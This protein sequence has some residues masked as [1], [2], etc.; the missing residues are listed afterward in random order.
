MSTLIQSHKRHK[1]WLKAIKLIQNVNDL[2]VDIR[3][4]RGTSCAQLEGDQFFDAVTT[5]TAQSISAAFVD[6]D[7][8]QDIFVDFDAYEHFHEVVQ[9]WLNIQLHW[10]SDN[11]FDNFQKHSDL[12]KEIQRLICLF[13]D[14]YVEQLD[15]SSDKSRL[16]HFLLQ[17]HINTM[18]S[19]ARLRGLGCFFCAKGQLSTADKKVLRDEIKYGYLLWSQHCREQSSLSLVMRG[20]LTINTSSYQLN[21]LMAEFIQLLEAVMKNDQHAPNG[22]E[23]FNAGSR[24]LSSMNIQ[25]NLGL[26]ELKQYL[27]EDLNQWIHNGSEALALASLP[28]AESRAV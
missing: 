24:I 21:C 1:N 9:M 2:C 8:Q 15:D 10:Q 23:V 20:R 28:M 12:L 13:S 16:T 11:A 18:E 19:V 17:T 27:P 3:C 6:L 22:S 7:D 26:E 14:Y 4:H 5:V 25:I